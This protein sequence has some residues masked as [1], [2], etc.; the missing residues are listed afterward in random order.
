MAKLIKGFMFLQYLTLMK[1]VWTCW[2]AESASGAFN[3]ELQKL[4]HFPPA[5]QKFH[6]FC[7]SSSQLSVQQKYLQDLGN[8]LG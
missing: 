4:N 6:N 7:H 3:E 5:L 2:D 8:V 1:H